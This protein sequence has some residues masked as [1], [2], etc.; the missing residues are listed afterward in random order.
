M[1]A[2][3]EVN[4]V[5]NK[6]LENSNIVGKSLKTVE[7]VENNVVIFHIYVLEV[8]FIALSVTKVRSLVLAVEDKGFEEAKEEEVI[9]VFVVLENLTCKVCLKNDIEEG[10]EKEVEDKGLY[11]GFI[12]ILI[13][14]R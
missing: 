3:R 5:D 14:I 1:E 11:E 13:H 10:L 6:S 9:D 2:L 12:V 7:A 8:L 4:K